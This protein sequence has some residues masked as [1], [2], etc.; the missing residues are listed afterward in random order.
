VDIHVKVYNWPTRPWPKDML[1]K[2]VGAFN[3][4]HWSKGLEDYI[5]FVLNKFGELEPL[6]MQPNSGLS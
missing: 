2:E 6:F 1:L 3:F 4:H 5:M